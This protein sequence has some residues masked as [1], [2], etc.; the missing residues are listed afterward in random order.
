MSQTQICTI[1]TNSRNMAKIMKWLVSGIETTDTEVPKLDITNDD[2]K[3]E[4]QSKAAHNSQTTHFTQMV[5]YFTC[6]ALRREYTTFTLI[7]ILHRI[8]YYQFP[9]FYCEHNRE[10]K[11]MS[12][13]CIS[14]HSQMCTHFCLQ[15][16][17]SESQ[18]WLLYTLILIRKLIMLTETYRNSPSVMLDSWNMFSSE[19]CISW[20]VGLSL[21]FHCQ[22]WRINSYILGGQPGGI[23]MRYPFSSMW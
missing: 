6:I 3:Q 21:G 17:I 18:F 20:K 9:D 19:W 15:E 5:E 14:Q 2:I 23:S 16:H 7:L 12:T 4:E 13:C 8:Q 10:R 1:Q 11:V 22:H